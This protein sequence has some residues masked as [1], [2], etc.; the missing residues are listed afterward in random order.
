MF[1]A[2]WYIDSLFVQW[3]AALK[4]KDF[5]KANGISAL[6]ARLLKDAKRG[7]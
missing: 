2:E 6:I 7:R 5:D 3:K 1:R 4:Q